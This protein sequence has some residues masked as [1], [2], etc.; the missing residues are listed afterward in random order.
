MF[1][2]IENGKIPVRGSKYS[3]CVDL[4]AREETI[5]HIGKTVKVPLGVCLDYKSFPLYI[6]N[7]MKSFY[8]ELH[9]RSSM[10][11]KN[12]LIGNVGVIDIDYTGEISVV[13]YNGSDSVC[14]IKKDTRVAQI[15][16]LEHK[17][18]L[19]D[20]HSEAERMGGFGST[21]EE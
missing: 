17:S 16:L 10:M 19:F 11:A 21:G 2:T 14:V 7:N 15:T 4:F 5:V 3:A 13:F 20:I 6:R 8:L 9:P 18:Y 1:K 12:G